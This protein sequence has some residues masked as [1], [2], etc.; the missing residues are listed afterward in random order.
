VTKYFGLTEAQKEPDVANIPGRLPLSLIEGLTDPKKARLEELDVDSCQA[1]AGHNPF[2]IWA[3]TSY[4]LLHIVDWIAQAQLVIVVKDTGI[5]KLR[6]LGVRDVFGLVTAL[7]GASKEQVAHILAI[8]PE[9]AY[10]MLK[11]LEECPAFKR[12]SDVYCAL[13]KDGTAVA[14]AAGPTPPSLTVVSD[15]S[16]AAAAGA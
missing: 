14:N 1:L 4:Q 3:R 8:T 12:L 9:M 16:S 15:Q 5:Q 6:A 7:R 2:L 10:D 11:Y 13:S